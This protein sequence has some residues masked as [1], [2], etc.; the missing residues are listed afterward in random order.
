M[1]E[2]G[3]HTRGH[4]SD[5]AWSRHMKKLGE[6]LFGDRLIAEKPSLEEIAQGHD[7]LPSVQAARSILEKRS[8][9]ISATEKKPYMCPICNFEGKAYLTC[10][11]P[12]CADG[13][14]ELRI[15]GGNNASS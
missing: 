3:M 12:D 1:G 2:P 11:R 9:R 7:D 13:R 4:A 6:F 15:K 8:I 14:E 5:A 10:Q